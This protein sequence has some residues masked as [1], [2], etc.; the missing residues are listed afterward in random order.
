MKTRTALALIVGVLFTFGIPLTA[1]EFRG[2]INGIVTDNSGA[3]LP[4]ATVTA[5]GPALIR[6]QSTIAGADGTY[7]FPALPAGVY[8]LTFE[9]AGFQK[10][11]RENIRVVI[12]TTLTLDA[13][14]A[15]ATLQ[16]SLTV[17]G[18]SPIVDTS[19]TTVGTNFTKELLTQIPNARD[20]WAAMA[21]APGFQVTGY[22][23]GGSHTGTQTGYVT[24]GVSQQNT[25]RIEGVNTSE[26]ASAN[27][28]YFDFGSFEEF[29]L[30]GAGNMADQ[31]VPGASLN[32]TVKSG[33]NRLMGS[34]YSDFE[35]DKTISN[36]VGDAFRTPFEK[37]EN[38]FFTRAPGGLTRGNPIT[39]Q[40][41]LNFNVGGPIWKN[42]AW[43]FYSYRLNDQYKT[44][45]G[46]P[47]LARSKLTNPFT[48]KGTFQL[49]RNNQLIAYVN[50]RE[51]LQDKRDLG[52]TT[53]LS[54][55]YYQ[56]SRNYPVKVEWTSVLSTKLF[57]DVLVGNWY[58]FF[59]LRPQTEVGGF[60]VDQ[61][62]AGRL[63][64][65]TNN[66]FDG[67]AN[68]TYQDQKRY[69]PQLHAYMSFFQNGWHG[70]HDFKVG[71]EARR[72]RRK[73]GNDQP[74]NI[75]YRDRGAAT[76]EV[77]LFNGP[78]E[79]IN[80]VN[81]RS[82]YVQDGWKF[83]SR[84][85]LNLGLRLDHY[86]DGWPEQQYAPDGLPQLA[87]TT[88]QR[89]ID[90][91]TPSTIEAKVVSTSTTVGPRAGFAYDLRGNSKSVIKGFYGRFY[92]NSA[93]IIAD[94]QNPV[95]FAQ[96]RYVFVPCT[97]T[98]TTRCDLNGNRLLDSPEELGNFISTQGGGGFVTVDPNL[99]RP[100]GDEI[101]GHFEQELREGLSG[102][103]SY[104]YKN[105]RNEWAEVDL[106]RVDAQTVERNVVDRGPD[107]ILGNADD[108]V[109]TLY[110]IPAGTGT[111]RFFTNPDD[112]SYDSDYS[113]VEMAINR[114]FRNGWMLLT[115]FEYTW[116]K[117]FV[118]VGSTTSVLSSA[119]NTKAYSWNRNLRQAD[120]ETT[121]IWNY[122]LIGRYQLPWQIGTSGSYKLQSGRQWG[123]SVSLS[124]TPALN[125]G[126]QTVRVEPVTANRAP[127]VHIV[128][129]RLDK[130]FQLK[131][132]IGRLTAMVDVFN[133]LNAGTPIVFRT[134]SG[135]VVA[136]E[137]FG[138]F[139]EIIA[140]LDP[141]IV[142]FG[143]RYE[144]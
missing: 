62:V 40:Y 131:N 60:P 91:Y 41:D 80:D 132:K 16:E 13:Q 42:R 119:G 54:A 9:L 57:L 32:I 52:P 14:L 43:F 102:R 20:I 49:S 19:T 69:K 111:Q 79:P 53:P 112:P 83:N 115:S 92:F 74:F 125:L 3:V 25:T 143:V 118:G 47:D 101:S 44:I 1:Q 8:T 104:V 142:R 82:V 29:Q 110:D 24:Y 108:A 66:L 46:M 4:G 121:T 37:D 12:N 64:L 103:F 95:G 22:D 127:N 70:S 75:F 113:T 78:V 28:G 130:S 139:K 56:S 31:D 76:S 38:G 35:N 10:I 17:S 51:K 61:F 109:R 45:I 136:G 86:T 77:E 128:D 99:K 94:N 84:L 93:D 137:P 2:R 71:F 141:R 116:L 34:W 117:E 138:N 55:A 5:S 58:N 33:G 85:T 90:F 135:N 123:R 68:N 120:R 114:R 96:L 27:A 100:Y 39:K 50:K 126:S 87:G 129:L 140:L 98:L 7:R 21:Q 26:G 89:I 81:V 18:Q 97:A 124:G 144:F 65:N 36:N 48:V 107:G 105:I 11:T 72:D 59:P 63:D 6:P 134:Q 23:V 106:A 122:K 133:L 30:G 73:L 15:V 67:G 88:D